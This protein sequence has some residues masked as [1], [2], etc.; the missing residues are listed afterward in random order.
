MNIATPT[1][2][3]LVKMLSEAMPL[4]LAPAQLGATPSGLVIVDEVNGFATVG[5]GY[6]APPAPNAQVARMV[7]E[8]DR[9]AKSF[10]AARR[11]ILAFLDTHVP[12]KAEPPYPPHCEAGTGE[13]NLVPELAWLEQDPHTTLVRK[14]CINGFVGSITPEGGNRV[15]DWVNRNALTEILVVGICTDIC[16][17][18]FVLTMLS[19]RNHGMMPSLKEILVYDAGCST[20]DLPRAVAEKLGLP[21]SAAHPQ[22]VAH[23]MGLYFM[24]SRGAKLV[25]EVVLK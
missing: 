13:E 16:V 1:H 15:V 21:S 25:N 2:N 3:P 11:P 23:Y 24:H 14:D 9:L 12:G 5:A 6:L 18:D 20:Y 17:M 22:D 8:T 4:S 7:E 19:A 10:S